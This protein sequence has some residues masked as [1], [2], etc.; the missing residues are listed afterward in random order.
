MNDT[1]PSSSARNPARWR[2]G[3]VVSLFAHVVLLAL[4]GVWYVRRLAEPS[5]SHST[6]VVQ[7]T[8]GASLQSTSGPAP[9]DE[10][11]PSP[12][13]KSSQIERQLAIESHQADDL[14]S[15]ER[16]D[17]LEQKVTKLNR[18]SSQQSI[19]EMAEKFHEWMDT[20]P[21]A[22]H[23]SEESVDG[24][25]DFNTA[26]IYDVHR[27]ATAN[28]QWEYVS[29]LLD[30]DGRTLEVTMD[31]ADGESVYRT[32]QT[33]NANP[34]AAQLYRQITMPLLDKLARTRQQIQRAAGSAAAAEQELEASPD[35]GKR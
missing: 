16:Q 19:N 24:P 2:I 21:R 23:P 4:F 35:G 6:E 29:V 5:P 8:D 12:I 7:Q 26:Q 15:Q 20:D 30:A 34:L 11:Q 32:M 27:N 3:F 10:A 25:F 13:V 31:A 9:P 17:E 22:Q 33:L 1:N 18:V 28:G 14:D